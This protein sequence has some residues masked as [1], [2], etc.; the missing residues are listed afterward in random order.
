M[1]RVQPRRTGTL[2]VVTEI[3]DFQL[4]INKSIYT[5]CLYLSLTIFSLCV[6]QNT[7]QP[8]SMWL[9]AYWMVTTTRNAFHSRQLA[10]RDWRQ[11]A[12]TSF[13]PCHKRTLKHTW[14]WLVKISLILFCAI[15]LGWC[16]PNMYS[17]LNGALFGCEGWNLSKFLY[18]SQVSI[19][20]ISLT[21]IQNQ[22]VH[23]KTFQAH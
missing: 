6:C 21:K 22:C 4:E 12:L 5:F 10:V 14:L 1:R 9:S 19:T 2:L 23:G 7:I 11:T 18:W 20:F 15:L 17:I 8:L 16:Q 13:S 3:I